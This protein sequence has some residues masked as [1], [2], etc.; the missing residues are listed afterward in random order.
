MANG[1][2][3]AGG[4][5][6]EAAARRILGDTTPIDIEDELRKRK[7]EYETEAVPAIRRKIQD[8]QRN[9]YQLG[10]AKGFGGSGRYAQILGREVGGIEAGG[11]AAQLAR[12]DQ[13]R[14]R[15]RAENLSERQF[16]TTSILEA[17]ARGEQLGLSQEQLAE[18][19]RQFEESKPKWYDYA[20]GVITAGASVAGAALSGGKSKAKT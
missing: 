20:L 9:L 12:R 8:V 1:T 16:Y 5:E 18:R 7:Q 17:K 13:E 14:A 2:A 15:L 6:G 3:T 19:I 4:V 11:R 10:L